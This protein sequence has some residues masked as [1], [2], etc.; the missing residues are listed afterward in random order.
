LGGRKPVYAGI[1]ICKGPVIMGPLGFDGRLEITV[2]SDTVNVASRLDG[3]CKD[4]DAKLLV[5]GVG[6][7]IYK[8]L[9]DEISI[10]EHG[11]QKV[12]G[13]ANTVDVFEIVDNNILD[14]F[15]EGKHTEEFLHYKEEYINHLVRKIGKI[16]KATKAS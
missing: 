12:R 3:L 13:R 15:A 7:D 5:A 9:P 4:L 16:K 8:A 14:A 1:G 6:L 2:L 10:L 11:P